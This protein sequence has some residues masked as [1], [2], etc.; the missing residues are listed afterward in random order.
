VPVFRVFLLTILF[1]IPLSSAVLRGL[2]LMRL[3]VAADVA[4][5]VVAT[6]VLFALAPHFGALGAVASA[7][8]GSATF[9]VAAG[10]A[11]AHRLGFGFRDFLPWRRMSAVAVIAGG[12][13]L[14]AWWL[15][16]GTGPWTRLLVG[17]A[18]ALA[19]TGALLWRLGLVP[20][21]ERQVARRLAAR[22]GRSL[23]RA[24]SPRG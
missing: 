23:F 24:G 13:A 15:L 20:E 21:A 1:W 22:F 14:G 18:G 7:V 4:S 5:V 12:T 9:N 6:S 8:A 3:M 16:A 17:P 10:A 19:A 11:S 2:G